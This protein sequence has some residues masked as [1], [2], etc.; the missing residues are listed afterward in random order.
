[1]MARKQRSHGDGTAYLTSDGR[2][3]VEVVVGVDYRGK[4]ERKIAYAKTEVEA[5]A[6]RRAMTTDLANGVLVAGRNVTLSEWMHHWMDNVPPERVRPRTL[7]NYRSYVRTWVDTSPVGRVRLDKLTPDHL[8]K[9][10]KPLRDAK[11]STTTISQLHRIVSRA[12]T[13]AVQRG[14]LGSNPAKRMDA[15]QPAAF[16]PELLSPED[17]RKL[18]AAAETTEGGARWIV[19]MALGLRQGEALALAWDRIDLENG[20]IKIDRELYSLPWQHGCPESTDDPTNKTPC[21]RRAD[22]C[23]QRHSGGRFIGDPKSDA[24]TRSLSLPQQLTDILARHQD[25]QQRIRTEEGDRWTGFTAAT[26]ERLD[27]VFSQRDGKAMI[28]SADW[29]A[30]KAFLK[31][32]DVPHVRLHDARHTAATLLLLMGV[33]GRVVMEMMGWSATSMLKRYQHVLDVMK[34]DAAKKMGAALWPAEVEAGPE[35]EP[36]LAAVA[37]VLSMDA[38]R[39]RRGARLSRTPTK[40]PTKPFSG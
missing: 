30:W 17:A 6:K 27:L 5:N 25:D 33:D 29:S 18:R 31:A 15:P 39:E 11:R 32:A 23:K 8:D 3:R 4:P 37:G 36:P 38:F 34:V 12:L 1:M 40:T 20:T 28:A 2:W 7:V 24:G 26:G 16:N 35:P 10:Y 19:A 22:H 14:R 13:V 21:H 9:L